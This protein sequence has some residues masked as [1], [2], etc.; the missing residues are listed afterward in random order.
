MDKHMILYRGSLKSCNYHCSYCPFSKHPMS[1][2]ALDR[3]RMQ[4][5]SFVESLMRKAK[6]L[7]IGALMVVPYGEA[8]IH[9]WYWE[10][11]A[12]I[13]AFA[14]FDAV[15]IQTNLSFSV[16]DFLDAFYRAQGVP[17]K[18]KLWATFHPEM[19]HVSEFAARCRALRGQGIELCA[20][21][22]GVPEN[23]QLLREL[24]QALDGIYLW[25]NQM[26]GLRRPYTQKEREAFREIDPYFE[27]E[28]AL[29]PADVSMCQGRLFVEADGRLRTCNI[30][31]VLKQD[32]DS[33]ETFPTPECSRRQCTCYLAY[34][35]RTD[36]DN[37]ALFGPYPLFRIPQAH[38]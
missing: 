2:R 33:L 30:S 15:G 35:G 11:L 19:T 37:Q 21:C 8:M 10:G 28:L 16:S 36:L 3:D 29:V 17:Q 5:C 7:Q 34:G 31:R 24:K 12:Q 20:G 18:L 26:D 9:P 32:W 22:V 6:A 13:S 27:R 23:L 38:S 25:V 4:W 14:G 1:A